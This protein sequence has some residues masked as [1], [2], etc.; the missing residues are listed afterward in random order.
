VNQ[1]K[2]RSPIDATLDYN[3]QVFRFF[4]RYKN[5]SLTFENEHCKFLHGQQPN[6]FWI[7][8][9]ILYCTIELSPSTPS[10]F[11]QESVAGQ[12]CA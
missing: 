4:G 10:C 9:D 8:N 3:D 6:Y 5:K 1:S 12:A 2:I 11:K 7:K